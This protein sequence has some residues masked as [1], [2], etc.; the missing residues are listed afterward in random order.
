MLHHV[1]V[2]CAAEYRELFIPWSE[3]NN[4]ELI[5]LNCLVRVQSPFVSKPLKPIV[6]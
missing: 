4:P 1:W 2:K 3:A 6:G 5:A